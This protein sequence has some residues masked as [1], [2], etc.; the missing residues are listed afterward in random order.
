MSPT[1][2]PPA[3]LPA[4]AFLEFDS[5]AAGIV[6]ADAMV[7]R[8]PVDRIAAGTVQPGRYLIVVTGM[9]A[10]VEEAVKAANAVGG[11]SLRDQITLPDIHPQ[12]FAAMSGARE[13]EPISALG[14]IETTTAP[15]AVAAADAGIKGAEVHLLEVRFS[16][17]L[18]GK[19]LVFFSGEVAD[20]EAAVELGSQSLGPGQLVEAR[21]IAQL[22][23]EVAAN[24]LTATR[25]RVILGQD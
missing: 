17:G 8:A 19:G 16:D 24:L 11:N 18:G 13:H 2:P 6:A 22:H 3:H 9:V 5:V 25:L 15:A 14:I 23:S 10:P 4:L 12:V 21:V 1:A 7:K 20:V